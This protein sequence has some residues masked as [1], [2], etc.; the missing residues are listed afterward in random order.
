MPLRQKQWESGPPSMAT[1]RGEVSHRRERRH[2]VERASKAI[3]S[4]RQT[5]LMS[6]DTFAQQLDQAGPLVL[7][8]ETV[9]A[10]GGARHE[11]MSSPQVVRKHN[12]RYNVDHRS[13][14]SE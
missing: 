14:S 13:W 8:A 11:D 10:Y 6:L 9:E 12:L 4:V 7:Q 5:P 2:V 3:T 1:S